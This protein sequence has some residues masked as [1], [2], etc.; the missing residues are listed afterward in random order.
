MVLAKD[1]RFEHEGERRIVNRHKKG[2]LKYAKSYLKEVI[3]GARTTV[4]SI[5][6]IQG[7]V[8]ENHYP[9]VLFKR[10]VPKRNSFEIIPY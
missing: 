2:Q 7:I 3:F 6:L 1:A 8:K 5:A 10:A 4:E 9:D